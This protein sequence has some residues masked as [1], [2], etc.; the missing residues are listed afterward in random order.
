MKASGG[1]HGKMTGAELMEKAWGWIAAALMSA[2][3][4]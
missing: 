4:K 2:V 3:E 1:V